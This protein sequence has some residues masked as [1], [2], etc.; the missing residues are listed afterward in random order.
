MCHLEMIQCEHHN[1]GCEVRMACKD[2]EKYENEKYLI[3]TKKD[4]Q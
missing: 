1:V 2:Q 3:I 4:V